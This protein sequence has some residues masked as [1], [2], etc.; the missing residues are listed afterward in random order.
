M[1]S[2]IEHASE[3]CERDGVPFNPRQQ[4]QLALQLHSGRARRDAPAQQICSRMSLVHPLA[5]RSHCS[6]LPCP[7]SVVHLLSLTAERFH[8][9]TLGEQTDVRVLRALHDECLEWQH[10]VCV[11]SGW[12]VWCEWKDNLLVFST[13]CDEIDSILAG[14]VMTD[15]VTELVGA[16][17]SGTTQ[18]AGRLRTSV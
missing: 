1:Q 8:A 4:E 2:I 9:L 12:D 18:A 13:G 10:P 11:R 15:E 14:G 3:R 17:S 16:S 6:P 7:T 5:M